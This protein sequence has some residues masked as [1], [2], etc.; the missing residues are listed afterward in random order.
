MRNWLFTQYASIPD[1]IAVPAMFIIA[2]LFV[3]GLTFAW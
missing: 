3:I 1:A 2:N